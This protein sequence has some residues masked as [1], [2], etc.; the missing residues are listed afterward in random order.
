MSTVERAGQDT[1]GEL[2]PLLRRFPGTRL[3]D[4]DW[5]HMLFEP[6]WPI[7]ETQR[8]FVLRVAGEGPVGFLGT[9]FSSR[10]IAGRVRRF[11]HL[12]SWFVD[13]AHRSESLRLVLPV[14]ALREH[15]LVNMS[16]SEAAHE[17]FV[18]LG[19]QELETAQILIP[20]GLDPR[21]LGRSARISAIRDPRRLDEGLPESVRTIVADT[22]GTRAR[23]VQLTDGSSRCLVVATRSPWKPGLPLAQIEYASDWDLFSEWHTRAALAFLRMLG[24]VGLRV[25]RRHWRR[26]VPAFA[27][28]RPLLRPH[29]YRPAEPDLTPEL[30][31]GLYS[32][33]LNQRW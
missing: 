13:Q 3:A 4:D 30:V 24:T 15:T 12:S 29:L 8:G 16:A 20:V 27:T 10:P 23:L 7:E 26:R 5:R 11:C 17:I 32:E 28:E 1:F 14:L 9:L 33:R 6:P 21:A 2:L 22:I 18:R 19:F 31:D 25:D